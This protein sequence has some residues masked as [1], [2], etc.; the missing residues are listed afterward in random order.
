[1]GRPTLHMEDVGTG[2]LIA[3]SSRRVERGGCLLC[4]YQGVEI[5][6]A[7]LKD[8]IF[9]DP[10]ELIRCRRTSNVR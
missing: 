6:T 3:R 2:P 5:R 8:Q 7:V 1:M 4:V 10:R 9:R